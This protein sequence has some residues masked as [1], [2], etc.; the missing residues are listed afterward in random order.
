MD[1]Q[2]SFNEDVPDP[3]QEGMRRAREQQAHHE[4]LAAN[5]AEMEAHRATSG[6]LRAAHQ[7]LYPG[8]SP[9]DFGAAVSGIGARVGDGVGEGRELLAQGGSFNWSDVSDSPAPARV[10]LRNVNAHPGMQRGAESGLQ[11]WIRENR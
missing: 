6:Q 7:G 5:A 4:R 8:M 1:P 3:T 10:D 2:D 11:R 9:T